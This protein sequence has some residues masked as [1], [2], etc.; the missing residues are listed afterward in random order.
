VIAD[1]YAGVARRWAQGATIVYAPIA[2]Q[3]VGTS[4]HRL[5][6]RVVLDVGAGT[7]VASEA[8]AAAG[9]S[10][11]AADLSFD[12]LAWDMARR[13]PA[14]V[15]DVYAL[16]FADR[17]VDDAVAAF[18][19]NHL[20]EP[21]AGL[22]ELVR[23]TRPGG[24]LLACVYANASRSEVRDAM[25]EAARHQGWQVPDWYLEVKRKA[26]PMLGTAQDMQCAAKQARLVDVTVEE[27]SVDVGVTEPEQLVD[28]RLGQAP[29]SAWLDRL[30]PDRAEQVRTALVEEIR[31]I[32][33]PYR[34]IVVFLAA[35]VPGAD[36]SAL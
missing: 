2:R 21:S 7:G 30:G 11:V 26:T 23:V 9:A 24:G 22:A 3:L 17:S 12:M 20:F 16:P 6:G 8:L 34:P 13:P 36:P 14:V 19:L 10:V 28:Y 35:L 27:R 15:A 4:P 18:V 5:L 1:H 32:M 33:R 31:S 29:F 25:D